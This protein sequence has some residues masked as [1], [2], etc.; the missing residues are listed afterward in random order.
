MEAHPQIRI[1]ED[2]LR[3]IRDE[4]AA[5]KAALCGL[6]VGLSQMS[7]VHGAVISQSLDFAARIEVERRSSEPQMDAGRLLDAIRAAIRDYRRI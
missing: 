6:Y 3:A 4:N 5:L 2:Q 1:L 7:D